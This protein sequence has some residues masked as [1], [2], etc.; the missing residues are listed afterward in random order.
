MVIVSSDCNAL[1]LCALGAIASILLG[2][3]VSTGRILILLRM[4]LFT[5]MGACML[6]RMLLCHY[7]DS[8]RG[9]RRP[10]SIDIVYTCSMFEFRGG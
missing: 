4:L 3:Q 8:S 6:L 5:S 9:N 7:C 1:R 2:M 10:S